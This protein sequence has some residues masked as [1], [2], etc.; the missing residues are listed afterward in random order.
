MIKVALLTLTLLL[1]ACRSEPPKQWTSAP[2]MR[3]DVAKQYIATLETD[4]GPIEVALSPR[5]APNTVNNFVFLAREGFYDGVSFHRV[6][7]NFMVQTGDPSGTGRGGPG[8]RIIDEPVTLNYERGVVAMAN[9]GVPNTGAS[10]F[11]IVQGDSVFLPK[12]YTIF[13]KVTAGLDVLDAI[14]SAPVSATPAGELSAPQE[15]IRIKRVMIA[16][17]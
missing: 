3:I 14:A 7:K 4:R 10:Q 15:I 5:E 13:G 16:E 9:S 8:Y 1:A 2:S 6:I 11:F 12:S 17:R